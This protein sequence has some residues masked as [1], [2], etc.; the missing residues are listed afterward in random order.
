MYYTSK[1]ICRFFDIKRDTLRHYEAMGIIHPQ[2]NPENQYRYY[3]E[4]DVY[5]ISECKKYQTLGMPLKEISA[6]QNYGTLHE[7][8]PNTDKLQTI[9][10]ERA[11]YYTLL[12]HKNKRYIS[13]LKRIEQDLN[14]CHIAEIPITYFFPIIH[15]TNIFSDEKRLET[16]HFALENFAFFENGLH[17]SL[18]DYKKD[19]NVFIW[20]HLIEQYYADTLHAP[21]HLAHRISG[22]KVVRCIINAGE[23]GHFTYDLFRP[24]FDYIK[25]YN[26]KV[27]DD[28]FGILLTRVHSPNGYCRYF[29]IYVPIE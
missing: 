11:R 17:V 12:A 5:A 13:D 23:R 18:D 7:L 21:V 14:R 28:I 24:I 1:D 20:G 3:D 6:L 27:V 22:N 8:I 16:G 9:L 25:E 15:D 4:W 26:L 19:T 29:D 10:E 2:I